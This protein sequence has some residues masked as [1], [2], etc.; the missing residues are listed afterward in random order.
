[1]IHEKVKNKIL[2]KEMLSLKKKVE[3]LSEENKKLKQTK[4]MVDSIIFEYEYRVKLYE[5]SKQKYDK[6]AK[7]YKIKMLKYKRDMKKIL[8]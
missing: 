2:Q 3:M 5:E 4:D 6:M 7:E 1:M 8:N